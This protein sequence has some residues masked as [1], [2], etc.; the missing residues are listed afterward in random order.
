MAPNGTDLDLGNVANAN[1][2]RR[3]P[4]SASTRNPFGSDW[5]A[6]GQGFKSPRSDHCKY[7]IDVPQSKSNL[8]KKGQEP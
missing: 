6:K 2:R 1:K 4:L 5:G 8:L 7:C 3:P